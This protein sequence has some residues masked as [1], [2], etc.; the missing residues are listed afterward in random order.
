MKPQVQM[1]QQQD[2]KISVLFIDDDPAVLQT[3]AK[4]FTRAGFEVHTAESGREGIEKYRSA[5]P[6][7]TVL[8]LNMPVLSGMEVL[9]VLRREQAVVI[10]LTG[11]A[12]LGNAVEAM[13]RGAENF[14]AK[15]VDMP[16]LEAAV[17]KAAEKASYRREV[18]KLRA[19]LSLSLKRRLIRYAALVVLAAVA[20]WGG[21]MIGRLGQG[22]ERVRGPI[23][24]PL[25]TLGAQPETLSR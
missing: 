23:P 5:R 11:H 7:V 20:L 1:S 21:T 13:Q 14:I 17:E 19:Q 25:D 4:H 3:F 22:S 6:D 16:H 12:E 8:D 10:M 24:I 15:P 2:H 9:D 18:V